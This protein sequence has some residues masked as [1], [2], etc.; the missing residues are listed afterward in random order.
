M[1]TTTTSSTTAAPSNSMAALTA[2]ASKDA[3]AAAQKAAVQ[4]L[5]T[6]MGAGSGVDVASLAQNL[7]DAERIPKENSI[8]KKITTNESRI[9]GYSAISFMVS[10]L[11]DALTALKN[12]SSFNA[13]SVDNSNTSA[14]NVTAGATAP[15]GNFDITVSSLSKSQKS[16]SSGFLDSATALNGGNAFDLTLTGSN[17]G[18]A[19]GSPN[20]ID[21]NTLD[22]VA[23]GTNPASNDFKTFS[24]NIDGSPVTLTPSPSTLDLKG[25]A[26]DLQSQLRKLSN[27]TDL[28]V[29]TSGTSLSFSSASKSISNPT[30][31][32]SA[33]IS[34]DPGARIGSTNTLTSTI[35]DIAFGTIPNTTDFKSFEM[36]LGGKKIVI[37]PS[38]ATADL[39]GLAADLQKQIRL[40]DG[41]SDVSVNLDGT[42]KGLVFTSATSRAIGYPFL[43]ANTFP[44]TPTG[45]VN[46]INN[47]NRGVKAPIQDCFDRSIWCFPSLFCYQYEWLKFF[48]CA[49]VHGN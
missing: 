40:S 1:A 19:V 9:S 7:V 46:A 44:D 26:A 6:S 31:S 37:T 17:I 42:G 32:Q 12:K 16:M 23:F 14:F 18:V 10:N 13:I 8:N 39:T 45:V 20:G 34:L 27:G 28:I 2:N 49:R 4:K 47:A 36:T 48:K 33:K 22:G 5:K 38:P 15:E 41:G 24:L 25:L 21:P 30:L 11:K 29:T 43:T 35:S 3:A